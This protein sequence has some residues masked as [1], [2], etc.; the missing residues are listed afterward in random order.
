MEESIHPGAL[1]VA[2]VVQAAAVEP[3]LSG[4]DR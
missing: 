4:V 1:K 3:D 2:L